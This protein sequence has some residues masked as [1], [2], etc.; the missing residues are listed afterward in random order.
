MIKIKSVDTIAQIIT[1]ST[2]ERKVSQSLEERI[3]ELNNS[4]H[5]EPNEDGT[6]SED[7]PRTNYTDL[8]ESD[9]QKI[10]KKELLT[11]KSASNQMLKR[12]TDE[13]NRILT[14]NNVINNFELNIVLSQIINFS[15]IE[16]YKKEISKIK[17]TKDLVT[18]AT[19][20]KIHNQNNT[21]TK[22]RKYEF[23]N[24]YF[25]I[26]N[27]FILENP[28]DNNIEF[29]PEAHLAAE[30][31]NQYI[32]IDEFIPLLN[33][34]ST[35]EDLFSVMAISKLKD[36]IQSSYLNN[37]LLDII[38][39]KDNNEFITS[40]KPLLKE[41]KYIFKNI[42]TIVQKYERLFKGPENKEINDLNSSTKAKKLI[43]D[44]QNLVQ[45]LAV[46]NSTFNLEKLNSMCKHLVEE[47]KKYETELES[48]KETIRKQ[49]EYYETNYINKFNFD[50]YNIEKS[51]DYFLELEKDLV[52]QLDIPEDR[53]LNYFRETYRTTKSKAKQSLSA[54]KNNWVKSINILINNSFKKISSENCISFKSRNNLESLVNS[55]SSYVK[56]LNQ[57]KSEYHLKHTQYIDIA[58]SKIANYDSEI[59]EI[60]QFTNHKDKFLS[61]VQ[62]INVND[63]EFISL[64]N[65][66]LN[67]NIVIK[68]LL[69][70]YSNDEHIN[71]ISRQT[72]QTIKLI[73]SEIVKKKN[74]Y[75]ENK[76]LE[77]RNYISNIENLKGIFY[78]NYKLSIDTIDAIAIIKTKLEK[79]SLNF[80]FTEEALNKAIEYKNK[81]HNITKKREKYFNNIFDEFNSRLESR[82]KFSLEELAVILTDIENLN[83]KIPVL[84]K[85]AED[86]YH[87]NNLSKIIQLK[88]KIN[89]SRNLYI[90]DFTQKFKTE[91]NS[92]NDFLQSFT[93]NTSQ[94]LKKLNQKTKE[95]KV[96]NEN[97]SL[98]N[99]LTGSNIESLNDERKSLILKALGYRKKRKENLYYLNQS[100]NKYYG[101]SVVRT[102]KIDEKTIKHNPFLYN[103]EHL[104][105]LICSLNI[106]VMSDN[107]NHIIDNLR[108]DDYFNGHKIFELQDILKPN[109][110]NFLNT[111]SNIDYERGF[112][113]EFFEQK[114][115]L[116]L[117][118]NL[119]VKNSISY[120]ENI[121]LKLNK[122]TLNS[123]EI[124]KQIDNTISKNNE[125]INRLNK[126]MVHYQNHKD[127]NVRS[128]LSELFSFSKDIDFTSLDS[129]SIDK[130]I[131]QYKF[132]RK[133]KSLI[134]EYG[135]FSD[136]TQYNTV[137]G[138]LNDFESNLNTYI[139]NLK[140]EYDA[141]CTR[142][143][144]K[145]PFMK[146][147]KLQLEQEIKNIE[148]LVV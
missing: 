66:H 32:D 14:H 43:R 143:T 83:E 61:S 116:L 70:K 19:N 67:D 20:D 39:N 134:D 81:Y 142:L 23:E 137:V 6:I 129:K 35:E 30:I 87:K 62:K 5:I 119:K 77:V 145:I 111:L 55:I 11:L 80:E 13:K 104:N 86:R 27:K 8:S 85:I 131:L 105:T 52:D 25:R 1:K 148:E 65:A 135:D 57:L 91:K 22:L 97:I 92:I 110:S 36:R 56:I 79:L 58:Q 107:E 106:M 46:H 28:G 108:K 60:K 2:L 78:D 99:Q 21:N 45:I 122:I 31:L 139:L 74:S 17:N 130:S 89:N 90:S 112:I 9:K 125:T 26:I 47:N 4:F 40:L 121:N 102:F 113:Q 146:R 82:D 53:A 42:E 76:K 147:K 117:D 88:T 50:T 69:E 12:Y 16:K 96:I 123:N 84:Q 24:L 93:C 98:F 73:D 127:N 72:S 118:M 132:I 100:E 54:L 95:I 64:I 10:W 59:G 140:S 48:V 128:K 44:V 38:K 138:K 126:Y 34:D 114:D 3:F 68:S 33:P 63:D 133:L 103:N 51:L 136:D 15:N 71:E 49:I 115:P 144:S 120:Y 37:L 7:Y 101:S 109:K 141:Q 124:Q 18:Q 29:T 94:S 75:L 41:D